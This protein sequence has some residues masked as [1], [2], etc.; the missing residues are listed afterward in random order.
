MAHLS[1]RLLGGFELE[2]DGRRLTLPPRKAQA[3]L[4]YLA[5]RPGRAHTREALTVLLW[6]DTTGARARQSLRQ[7]VLRVRR[8]FAAAHYHSVSHDPRGSH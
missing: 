5:L 1:L 7:T 4:A 6:S 2:T 8:A 3:L